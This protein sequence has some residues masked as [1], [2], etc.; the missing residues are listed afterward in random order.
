MKRINI[1]YWIFTILLAVFMI[2]TAYDNVLVGEN[3]VKLIHDNMQYPKYIIPFLG[4]AKC[5]AAIVI[6]IPGIPR[7]KEWAFAGFAF[8]MAGAMYSSIALGAAFKDWVWFLLFFAIEAAA[9]IVLRMR[10]K[11]QATIAS[12]NRVR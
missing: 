1:L 2:F 4:I 12:S 5:L 3:S 6:L 8:D 9:Y 10:Q 11:A 7:L